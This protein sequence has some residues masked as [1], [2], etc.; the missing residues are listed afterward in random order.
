MSVD[1]VQYREATVADASSIAALHADSW[2]RHYRGAYPASFF[3]A[4]LDDDRLA[5]WSDRLAHPE[6]TFTA[7]AE[8]SGLAG[9]IHVRV[10]DDEHWG[11]LIDNLHVRHDLQRRGIAS[12]LMRRAAAEVARRAPGRGMYLWVLEQNT[13]AQAFYTAIGGQLAD[14]RPVGPPAFPHTL[15]IRVFWADPTEV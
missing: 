6:G 1:R 13:R 10:D 11:A 3:D 8:L 2:R 12:A 4:S 15:G 14:A 9:F 5:V 7:V